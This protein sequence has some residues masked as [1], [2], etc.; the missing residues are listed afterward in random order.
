M[1]LT[2]GLMAAASVLR[3]ADKIP[4]YQQILDAMGKLAEL[5]AQLS[6]EQERSRGLEKELEA[7]RSDQKKA[8][9]IKQQGEVYVL[10]GHPYCPRC[11]EVDKRLGPIVTRGLAPT[12][13]DRCNAVSANRS[14]TCAAAA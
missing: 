9:G 10:D 6:A 5:Q 4:E 3:S 14:S 2:D 11:W 12:T 8:E 1:G 7:I 13:P